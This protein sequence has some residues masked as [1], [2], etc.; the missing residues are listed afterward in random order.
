MREIGETMHAAAWFRGEDEK[1]RARLVVAQAFREQAEAQRVQFGPIRWSDVLPI[2]PRLSD[3]PGSGYMA[4]M[5]EA[6]IVE[7]YP[8]VV[9]PRSILADLDHRDLM[10]LREVTRRAHRRARP[11]DTPLTDAQ[12][13]ALIDALAPQT[14]AKLVRAAV[15][16]RQVQ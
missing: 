1:V 16:T 14:A 3:P 13:D 10:R 12:A 5:G 7:V 9:S 15:D 4:L 6:D 2:D 8:M 11:N